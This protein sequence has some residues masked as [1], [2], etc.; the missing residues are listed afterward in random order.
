MGWDR[1]GLLVTSE[2]LTLGLTLEPGPP[3]GWPPPWAEFSAHEA[4]EAHAIN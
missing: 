3:L 2:A 1:A 4:R